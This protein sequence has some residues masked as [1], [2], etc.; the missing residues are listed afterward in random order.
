[1]TVRVGEIKMI[2]KLER[3]KCTGCFACAQKCP[4]KC[5]HIVTDYEGFLTPAIDHEQCI[6]CNVCEK[7][8]PQ[9][10]AVKKKLPIETYAAYT[11]N[12]QLLSQSTSGG[13]FAI[14]AYMTL[15][16]GGVVFGVEMTDDGLV[17]MSAI[18]R[19]EELYKL[20]GSKYVQAYIGDSYIQAKVYLQTNRTV[21]FS[22]TPCQIAGLYSFLGKKYEKLYTIEIVCH[23]VP[24]QELFSAYRAWLGQKMGSE[25][26][27][28]YFRNKEKD[29]WAQIDKLELKNR[30]VY[31][32]E[33]LDPYT[34]SYLKSFT[35]RESCYECQFCSPE[36]CADITVGD[37]WG[38]RNHHP[39]FY[40][41]LGVCLLLVNTEHGRDVLMKIRKSTALL[42]SDY[43]FMKK[44]NSG[45][46]SKPQRPAQRENFYDDFKHKCMDEFVSQNM[47]VPFNIKEVLRQ[48]I[49]HRI[50]LIIKEKLM[51]R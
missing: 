5:I 21:L 34:Y 10:N 27:H 45:L 11:K 49:P 15:E 36:R 32:R 6:G 4:K 18:E 1:M 20:Q 50:R 38:L 41:D 8:C 29:G 39:E 16:E 30:S 17:R 31:R 44:Y 51:K 3:N 28:W 14:A 46:V 26:K 43:A 13:I 22:G 33:N 40:S 48:W 42:P 23:G 37:Y 35:L 12:E 24:S 47:K 9:L 2:N 25:I 7:V 19:K